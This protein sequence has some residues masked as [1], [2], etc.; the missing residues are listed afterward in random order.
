MQLLSYPDEDDPSACVACGLA[1]AAVQV[2]HVL[3][4]SSQYS[5]VLR[6]S[7]GDPGTFCAIVCTAIHN[8]QVGPMSARPVRSPRSKQSH[9]VFRYR[10][11]MIN[12]PPPFPNVSQSRVAD[13]GFASTAFLSRKGR[14]TT[15]QNTYPCETITMGFDALYP[16]LCNRQDSK[17]QGSRGVPTEM[18]N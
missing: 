6:T 11:P 16:E 17:G 8:T 2:P 14:S 3:Y 7:Y 12:I 5:S 13:L 18:Q 4:H 10:T 9:K 15:Q 1:V